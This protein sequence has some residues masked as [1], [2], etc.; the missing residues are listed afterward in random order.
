MTVSNTSNVAGPYAC[1]GSGT[2]FGFS[3]G[4]DDD[5]DLRVILSGME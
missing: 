4:I 1:D 3:F 2:T 5:D